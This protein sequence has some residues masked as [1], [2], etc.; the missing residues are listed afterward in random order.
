MRK[1]LEELCGERLR[2]RGEF[3]RYGSRP[4]VIKPQPTFCLQNVE[5]NGLI[6]ADHLWLKLTQA[7][8]QCGELQSGQWLEFDARVTQYERKPF[9]GPAER[10]RNGQGGTD[11]RLSWPS[12]IEIVSR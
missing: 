6:V 11:Y 9:M 2:F 1:Q 8:L 4:I 3:S 10:R 12:N 7:F 5:A